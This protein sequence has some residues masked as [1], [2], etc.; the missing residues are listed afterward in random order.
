MNF[1]APKTVLFDL[2]GTLADT[3]PLIV[4]TFQRTVS[5]ALGWEPTLAQCKEWIG[6]SLTETFTTLAPEVADELTAR[7]LEWNLANH[8][9]YVRPFDGVG[10]LIG[11]LRASGRP[12]GVVTSKRH[13][14]AL[15]SLECVGL[16]GQ[17]PL[18][19]TEED[20]ATHKPS[21]EPLLHALNQMGADAADAVYVGDA[22]VDMQAA[23]A[24]GVRGIGV[25]WGA[26][27]AEELRAAEP[28]A[29]VHSVGELQTLLGL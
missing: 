13:A 29:V 22:I 17:I 2:D 11:G 24:A 4:A 27:S 18:L 5:Q 16:T 14:S 3:V 20:T 10:A 26:A 12:F 8:Q 25:T 6:R 7:Y 21:P 23:R 28:T 1:E 9:A 15:V 19:V